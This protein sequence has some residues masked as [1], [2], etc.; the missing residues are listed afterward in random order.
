MIN[1]PGKEKVSIVKRVRA[2]EPDGSF[3]VDD[4]RAPIFVD[5]FIDYWC[6]VQP[7]SAQQ[8]SEPGRETP[9]TTLTIIG[10]PDM[11]IAAEDAVIYD[12][13]RWEVQGKP[14][15]WRHPRLSHTT[16]QVQEVT[17]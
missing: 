12:G 11:E 10:P 2:L 15:K 17:K 9:I 3:S 5:Q 16:F 7:S 4:R 13:G 14:T 1:V 6:S 8:S